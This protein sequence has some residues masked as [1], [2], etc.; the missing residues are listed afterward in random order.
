MKNIDP[1]PL[2]AFDNARSASPLYRRHPC[3]DAVMGSHRWPPSAFPSACSLLG[4]WCGAPPQGGVLTPLP[5]RA[6]PCRGES[7]LLNSTVAL[8]LVVSPPQN[9]PKNPLP[10]LIE[11]L[12][13][14]TVVFWLSCHFCGRLKMG[15]SS[16]KLQPDL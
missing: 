13:W 15:L 11:K 1:L 16:S 12:L 9:R 7:A 4:A 5:W 6:L 2:V 3:A 8:Y 14:K 10:S